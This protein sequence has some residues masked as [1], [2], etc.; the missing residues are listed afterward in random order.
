MGAERKKKAESKERTSHWPIH[1]TFGGRITSCIPC[2]QLSENPGRK[3]DLNAS[4]CQPDKRQVATQK[5]C[6]LKAGNTAFCTH[7]NRGKESKP[8]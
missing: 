5:D 3:R 2:Q 8:D 1:T 7:G 6:T 4:D